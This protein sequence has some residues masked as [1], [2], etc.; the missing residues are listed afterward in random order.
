MLAEQLAAVREEYEG[1]KN[2]SQRWRAEAETKWKSIKRASE[3]AMND[4]KTCKRIGDAA[5]LELSALKSAF[6]SFLNTLVGDLKSH[7]LIPTAVM[8]NVLPQGDR[9]SRIKRISPHAE[10]S[11]NGMS[12]AA[13]VGTMRSTTNFGSERSQGLSPSGNESES[14]LL[15][16]SRPPSPPA[17][18]QS[19]DSPIA[20]L[21]EA[22]VSD[23]MQELSL[24]SSMSSV[25]SSLHQ[26]G[27]VADATATVAVVTT[28]PT[29]PRETG[30][31][32]GTAGAVSLAALVSPQGTRIGVPSSGRVESPPLSSQF[33]K[34]AAFSARVESALGSQNTSAA[35]ADMLRSMRLPKFSWGSNA[36][37]VTAMTGVQ[38]LETSPQL[39]DPAHEQRE[40]SPVG[41]PTH[42]WLE[43]EAKDTARFESREERD[44]K[45]KWH[46]L[47]PAPLPSNFARE[48][49]PGCGGS[50]GGGS[51]SIYRNRDSS[52]AEGG[53]MLS[54]VEEMP[55][56][57]PAEGVVCGLGGSLLF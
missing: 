6:R 48:V 55:S 20:E 8:S 46:V 53:S 40:R 3:T 24:D 54:P 47:W 51:A 34:D 57:P 43:V 26:A 9:I 49:L 32:P 39:S 2:A 7:P 15:H 31:T 22:E 13:G 35:L 36:S 18:G 33:K 11:R 10:I 30:P 28:L 41:P 44:M 56:T 5:D 27:A 17:A 12:A 1:Y 38:T 25:S 52:R 37:E 50:D 45:K 21:T 42:D 29:P 14:G 19:H 23:I 4:A 16:V